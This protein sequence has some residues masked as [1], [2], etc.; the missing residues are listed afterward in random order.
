MQHGLEP[1][2]E[3]AAIFRAGHHGAEIE[4]QQFLVEQAFRHVAIDDAQRQT[5]DDRGL[6][7]A[8]LADQHR[9]VLGPAR[10]N[11]DRAAD[12][13]VAADDRIELAVARRLR[14]V[15][16]IFLQRVIGVFRRR[17]VGGAALA[18]GLDGGIEV[19]RRDA[20]SGEDFS[21]LG[22]TFEREREQEPLDRDKAV[23]GLLARLLG[24]IE[25]PAQS[26]IEIDLPCPAARNFGPLG[27]RRLDGGERRARIAAGAVDQAR[28]EPFRVVEQN[29]EQVFGRKLLVSLALGERLRRLHETAAAVGIFL[30]I[31]VYF[32][33][34]RR[35]QFRRPYLG[36]PC[37]THRCP[38]PEGDQ[39]TLY[40]EEVSSRKEAKTGTFWRQPAP[41]PA[42]FRGTSAYVTSANKISLLFREVRNS[43]R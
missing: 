9:I 35:R 6:A 32:L 20:G 33:P 41:E 22:A 5:L 25:H 27:Q 18:Q 23:A 3:L 36:A 1:L 31:H 12:F 24:G 26:R 8:G 11:L 17:G 43:P 2:L 40:G 19:L 38:A 13:L 37:D 15:A 29:L 39:L 10:K 42:S 34:S 16:G 14:Q 28:G 7:D 21:G 30:E 4:R